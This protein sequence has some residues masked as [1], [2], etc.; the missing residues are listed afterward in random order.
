MDLESTLDELYALRPHEFTAVRNQRA[1]EARRAGDR[2]LA[3]RIR[4]LRRPTVS[5]WAGNMLVRREPD[6]VGPLISLGEGLR[7]AHRN[8]DGEQLRELGRQ[9]HLLVGAL[10]RE[11]RQLAA[12]E[13]QA[14]GEAAFHEIEATLHA[15]LADPEAARQWAAG[16]LDRP[17]NAPVGFTGLEAGAGATARPARPARREPEPRPEPSPEPEEDAGARRRR[18]KLDRAR[19]D[20]EEAER[21]AGEREQAHEE[22]TAALERSQAAL[23]GISEQVATL[24]QE[25]EEARERQRRTERELR[26]TRDQVAR[27]SRTARDARRRAD[28]AAT[29]VERLA[30][31]A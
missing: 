6:K 18:E 14:V 21:Q 22:A 5:A 23:D 16:H 10:A 25:L 11:A 13:G 27:T 29:A 4:A 1:A 28:K 24:A 3:E 12:E 9:Q 30:E 2:E 17:L 20:A 8:L 31:G 7:E 26:D 15:V 19:Q